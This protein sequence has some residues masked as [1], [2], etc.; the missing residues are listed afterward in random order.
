MGNAPRR[1]SD[2]RALLSAGPSFNVALA[3]I[4]NQHTLVMPA[5]GVVHSLL[6]VGIFVVG[7]GISVRTP[8]ASSCIG[9][10]DNG[11]HR[12]QQSEERGKKKGCRLHFNVSFLWRAA[13]CHSAASAS[14]SAALSFQ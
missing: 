3:A 12:Q 13:L 6:V 1:Q 5:A 8:L 9:R 14:V 11:D 2:E 10:R 4:S 7:M